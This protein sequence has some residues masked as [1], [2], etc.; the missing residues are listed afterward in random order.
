MFIARVF[1]IIKHSPKCPSVDKWI[2]KICY[3]HV[4]D[5]WLVAANVYGVLF[6]GNENVFE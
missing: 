6:L 1:V 2:N 5:G 3:L 4:V